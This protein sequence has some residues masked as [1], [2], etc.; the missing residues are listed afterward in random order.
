MIGATLR[1]ITGRKGSF[2]GGTAVVLASVVVVIVVLVV[3]H[4]LRP[5]RNPSVGGQ[6]LLDGVA[7]TIT[8]FGVVVAILI[9]SLAG[10][11]DV[12]QGTMRYLVMTGARRGEIY[13]ARTAAVVIAVLLAIAPALLLGCVAALVLPHSVAAGV[14]GSEIADVVWTSALTATVFALISMGIGALL[15]SNGP[16]IAISLVF[17]LG[18]APLLLLVDR[19]SPTL[20]HLM[21]LGALDRLTGGTTDVSIPVAALALCAWV[22]AFWTAGRLRVNRDEY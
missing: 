8:L 6:S 7:G 21:L 3:V 18:F 10:S 17:F 4:A 11:Y 14:T 1:T 15:R 2:L 5:G 16:A 12:A 22:G 19:V 13:G 9:G 20:G